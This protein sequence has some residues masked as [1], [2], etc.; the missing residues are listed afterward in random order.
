VSSSTTTDQATHPTG[1]NDTGHYDNLDHL[2]D[3]VVGSRRLTLVHTAGTKYIDYCTVGTTT[4]T[5]PGD[6]AIDSHMNEPNAA[7]PKCPSGQT[8]AHTTGQPGYDTPS[9]DL[10]IG[11]Y[12]KQD[13]GTF[14]THYPATTYTDATS[15]WKFPSTKLFWNLK[16]PRRKKDHRHIH[17]LAYA[18]VEFHAVEGRVRFA[19]QRDVGRPVNQLEC[20]TSIVKSA[21]LVAFFLQG[22]GQHLQEWLFIIDDSH[23]PPAIRTSHG[24]PLRHHPIALV[25]SQFRRLHRASVPSQRKIARP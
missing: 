4:T 23:N 3:A 24:F 10:E 7:T 16:R 6:P 19:Q 9:G 18:P 1:F 21:N 8:W 11:D 15:R 25:T 5:Y 20:V 14:I 2:N 12:A 22:D 17:A 13:D